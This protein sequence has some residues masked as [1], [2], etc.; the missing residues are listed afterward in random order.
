MFVSG[1]SPRGMLCVS[2]FFALLIVLPLLWFLDPVI[3][4]EDEKTGTHL[5][6]NASS[7]FPVLMPTC[8]LTRYKRSTGAKIPEIVFFKGITGTAK[9][10]LCE[11]VN[12]IEFNQKSHIL[13]DKYVCIQVTPDRY[14]SMC[15][16]WNCV[17]QYR[18]IRLGL[19]ASQSRASS[20]KNTFFYIQR[21]NTPF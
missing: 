15:E 2:A 9:I 20:F 21:N 7:D 12:C 1:Y 6:S 19:S 10:D 13:S 3:P 16:E 8:P 4:R 18:K 14:G 17:C 5:P 11:V